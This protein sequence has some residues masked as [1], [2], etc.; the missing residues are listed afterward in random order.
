MSVAA[1]VGLLTVAYPA[2]TQAQASGDRVHSVRRLGGTSR[3]TPA[4][5]NVKAMQTAFAR[6]RTQRDLTTV[7]NTAGLSHIEAEVKKAIADGAV[8]EVTMAPGTNLQWMALRRGGTR[9]D[10][11][12]LVRWD[13]PKPFAGY[14]FVIDDLKE[15][16]TFVIPQDCGNISLVSREPSREAARREAE[17]AAA[18]AEE[19]RK[20]EEA[21]RA[22]EA[23]KAEEARRAAEAAAAEAA[24]KADEARRAEEARLA[25]EAAAAAEAARQAEAARLAEERELSLRP[26]VAGF[27]G[28]QRRQ[29]DE[30]DPAGLGTAF[31][32]GFCDP[33]VGTKVGFEKKLGSSQ[34]VIAPAVG[35]AF[36][37]DE[38]D[39][40]SLFVDGELNYK[41]GNGGYVGTGLGL[42]D[43]T[44]SD[45]LTP[46]ALLHFG[47]PL[48]KAADQRTLYFVTEGRVFFDRA[49]D[50]DSNYQFWGGLRFLFR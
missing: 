8:R 42:W 33:L 50:I 12:R 1:L 32:P 6:P 38:A 34:W 41:F 27:F 37:T 36:N 21:R 23:R 19:A 40:T 44:H 18:R 47:I 11:L 16:Y 13:G 10:I 24:R 7:L 26:F 5:R 25:A 39:R 48:W 22:E 49:S 3:F 14:E 30:N 17:A 4:I 28:K 15:T 9:A 45:S 35:V 43:F 46:N 20:A 31:L 29:Y 2:E